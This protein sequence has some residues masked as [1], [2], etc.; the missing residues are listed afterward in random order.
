MSDDDFF[1][2][3]LRGNV[4]VLQAM[5]NLHPRL[6]SAWSSGSAGRHGA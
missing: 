4:A 3:A 2:A 1:R 6:L 5:V